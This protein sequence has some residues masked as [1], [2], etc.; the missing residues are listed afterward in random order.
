MSV[1]QGCKQIKALDDPTCETVVLKYRHCVMR[2]MKR[3][4][5]RCMTVGV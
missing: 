5:K 2:C 1:A 4:M 3:C